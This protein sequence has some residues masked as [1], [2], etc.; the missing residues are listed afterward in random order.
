MK[1]GA[2]FGIGLLIAVGW[3]LW[4]WIET[5]SV[6]E[7]ISVTLSHQQPGDAELVERAIKV[8][9]QACPDLFGRFRR[10]VE[11]SRPTCTTPS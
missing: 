9:A 10:D 2:Y 5:P 7:P 4:D 6:P 1:Y 11:G 3:K 8:F